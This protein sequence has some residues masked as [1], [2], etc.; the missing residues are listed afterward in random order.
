MGIIKYNL[1]RYTDIIFLYYFLFY[2]K[3]IFNAIYYKKLKYWEVI[4]NLSDFIHFYYYFLFLFYDCLNWLLFKLMFLLFISILI[5]KLIPFYS[6]PNTFLFISH[7]TPNNTHHYFPF[8]HQINT[9]GTLQSVKLLNP[10][11]IIIYFYF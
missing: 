4:I 9:L 5:P 7:T 3:R 6:F 10:S 2:F 11:L 1:F 8:F